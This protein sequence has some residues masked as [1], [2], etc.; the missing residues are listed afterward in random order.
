M[1]MI[2]DAGSWILDV[3]PGL[4]ETFHADFGRA[5]SIIN[6]T[7]GEVFAS[8]PPPSGASQQLD[9]RVE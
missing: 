9:L 3:I 4:G 7:H 6:R 8:D 1:E 5:S 2:G